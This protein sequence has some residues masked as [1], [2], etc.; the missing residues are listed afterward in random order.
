MSAA[1]G[2]AGEGSA[3]VPLRGG[4]DWG[5]LVWVRGWGGR[6]EGG[7]GNGIEGAVRK[8]IL[9]RKNFS[10]GGGDVVGLLDGD[11]VSWWPVKE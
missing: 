6:V 8:V 10:E 7:F 4:R 9:K 3:L 2:R 5:E 1:G 11:G